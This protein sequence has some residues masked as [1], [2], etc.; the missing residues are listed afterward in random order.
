MCRREIQATLAQSGAQVV[1]VAPDEAGMVYGLTPGKQY[2]VENSTP[3]ND[4]TIS[5]SITFI[6]PPSGKVRIEFSGRATAE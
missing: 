1:V 3:I 2:A 4:L 6:A 5:T